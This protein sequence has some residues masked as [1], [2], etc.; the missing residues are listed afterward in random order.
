MMSFNSVTANLTGD[1]TGQA[2]TVGSLTGLI[3]LTGSTNLFYT[4]GRAQ[5]QYW[6]HRCRC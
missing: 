4:D 6:W 5:L 2:D 3:H 1:V